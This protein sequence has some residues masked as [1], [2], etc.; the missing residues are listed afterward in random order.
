MVF[1][2]ARKSGNRWIPSSLI[3]TNPANDFDSIFETHVPAFVPPHW[4]IP[5][6]SPSIQQN[7]TSTNSSENQRK[8]KLNWLPIFALYVLTFKSRLKD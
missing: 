3:L 8:H 1:V 2:C 7:P 5:P 4:Y 6:S